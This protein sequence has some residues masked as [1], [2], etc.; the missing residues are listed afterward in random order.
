MSITI[1]KTASRRWPV[2]VTQNVCDAAG[3]VT[4]IESRFVMHF[5]PFG[6]KEFEAAIQA[7]KEA[8]PWAV[9]LAVSPDSTPLPPATGESERPP[10]SVVLARNAVTFARL[11]VG[12]GEEVKDEAGLPVA[13]SS[14]TLE[15]WVTGPDGLAVSAGINRALAEIRFG[16]AALKN[17]ATSP[18]PGPAAV[19]V[20]ET[21][22][23]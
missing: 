3:V 19:G 12:W 20:S 1:R 8:H 21:A 16:L 11:I 2:V 13:Y 17:D 10:L 23:N 14:V 4:P 6:E 15:Q 7:G 18:A 22:L 9:Q 5:A